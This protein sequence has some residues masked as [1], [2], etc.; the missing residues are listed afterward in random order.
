MNGKIVSLPQKLRD[1][2]NRRLD[3]G[4]PPHLMARWLNSLPEVQSLF[5]S[6]FDSQPN[7]RQNIRKW[8]RHGFRAWKMRQRALEFAANYRPDPGQPV[9]RFLRFLCVS[10]ESFRLGHSG[11]AIKVQIANRFVHN[12]NRRFTV[13]CR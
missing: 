11:F 10:S 1:Q 7:S 2:L 13:V 9:L 6:S 12:A 5:G 3:N 8:S 4:E